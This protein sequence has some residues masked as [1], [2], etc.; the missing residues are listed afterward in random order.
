MWK[1]FFAAAL[2]AAYRLWQDDH[3]VTACV[4]AFSALMVFWSA[5]VIDNYARASGNYC[6]TG[7]VAESLVVA[8]NFLFTVAS[9]GL[10][11]Y[12]FF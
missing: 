11:V 5:G 12:S 10:Q 3:T 9:L 1:I 4:A 2:V 8:V 6:D 7:S